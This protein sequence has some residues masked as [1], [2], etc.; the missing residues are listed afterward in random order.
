MWKAT[1][2]KVIK[3]YG[4]LDFSIEYQDD[5]DGEVTTLTYSLRDAT[6]QKIRNIARQ[7]VKVLADLKSEVI[8]LPVG[9]MINID[10]E[11]VVTPSPPTAAELA[12]TAW[13]DDWRMLNKLSIMASN[14]LINQADTRITPLRLRLKDTWLDTYLDDL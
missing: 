5:S 10:P 6:D 3:H 2:S 8:D 1:L 4:R 11:P 12:R 14:G 9:Q 7:E 13:F